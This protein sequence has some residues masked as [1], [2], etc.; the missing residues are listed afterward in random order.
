MDPFVEITRPERRRLSSSARLVYLL[1]CRKAV[2][3]GCTDNRGSLYVEYPRLD[4]CNDLFLSV[5]TVSGVFKQL[6][7]E[8]LLYERRIGLGM[9]NRIYL[10]RRVP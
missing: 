4:L 6:Q 3:K 2:E 7:R 8:G 9:P 1:L 5:N 10:N